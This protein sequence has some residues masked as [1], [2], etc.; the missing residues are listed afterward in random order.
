MIKHRITGASAFALF[1]A[2]SMAAGQ[3]P[4]V[5]R[6]RGT[7]E[8]VEGSTLS[9]KDRSGV[10]L[11]IKVADNAPVNAVVKAAYSDIK[12]N[13]YIAVTAVPQPDGSQRAVAILIFP[14]ALRGIAEGHRPWDLSPNSTMTNGTVDTVTSV[15]GQT[16]LLKYKGGEQK[17]VV[18]ADA[19]I[20]TF[21]RAGVADLKPGAKIFIVAAKKLPDGTLEAPNVAFGDYGVWR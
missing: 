21:A 12:A 1:L 13:S 18:P 11:T 14:E 3:T 4:E 8:N 17:V 9:V 7:I 16:L 10:P 20:V 19:E 15:E 5:V 6:V 2:V